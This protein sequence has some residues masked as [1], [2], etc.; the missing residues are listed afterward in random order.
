MA[1]VTFNRQEIV[2]YKY[3]KLEVLLITESRPFDAK[4]KLHPPGSC[5]RW[6]ED[7]Y[8]D[9]LFGLHFVGAFQSNI[10]P[11][12]ELPAPNQ[13]GASMTTAYA[14]SLQCLWIPIKARPDSILVPCADRMHYLLSCSRL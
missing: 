13:V 4:E 1:G 2:F 8:K 7:T 9:S 6:D 3:H 12:T 14:Y 10:G 11:L 5:L